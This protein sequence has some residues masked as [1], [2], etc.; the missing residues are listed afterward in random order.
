VRQLAVRFLQAGF[1]LVE[2]THEISDLRLA[3]EDWRRLTSGGRA[4]QSSA[5]RFR[6]AIFG[7]HGV[8]RPTT[9]VSNS[10]P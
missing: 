2:K 1:E 3:I 7:A 8:T 10:T 9:G 4:R 5:R 6:L